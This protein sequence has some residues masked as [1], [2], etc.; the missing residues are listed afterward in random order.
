MI[1]II[2]CSRTGN[3]DSEL[4]VNIKATIG[5]EHEIIL[6]NN[7]D[8]KYGIC[9]AYNIGV[10]QSKYDILC[11]MHD[12][13]SY[14]TQNW[15]S[16]ALAHFTSSDAAAIGVA[17]SPYCAFMPGPWWGSGILYEN[18]LQHDKNSIEAAL[19]ANSGGMA[20]KEAILLDGAWFCIKKS[21]FKQV[22][23]DETNFKGFHFYDVDTCMQIHR[24]GGK[25][26]CIND[27]LI[28][29]AS[30]GEVN[31]TWIESALVFHQKW[32]AHLPATCLNLTKTEAGRL[33]YKTLN[34]FILACA[35][36][37]YTNKKIY[38]IALKS[39]LKFKQGYLFYKTPGYF[40]KFLFKY[41]LKKGAPFYSLNY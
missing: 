39:L 14:H 22:S 19:K 7:T 41:L 6:I 26:Y 18:L 20:R 31:S 29:H 9:Q 33:E 4:S 28:Q 34:S 17:G 1:S 12:D 40:V 5:I 13:I 35:A 38:A 10:K 32:A 30:L 37:K 2:I 11:F 3:L 8:N 21:T 15:G 25:I 36:N 23:F 24:A 16:N 27:V